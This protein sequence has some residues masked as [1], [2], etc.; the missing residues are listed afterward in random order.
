MNYI[1]DTDGVF[2]VTQQ[3]GINYSQ[4]H[5]SAVGSFTGSVGP[6]GTFDQNG[7]VWDVLSNQ[8]DHQLFVPMRGGG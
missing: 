1:L 4:N 7:S 5:L 2:S 8:G 6:Y 3:T